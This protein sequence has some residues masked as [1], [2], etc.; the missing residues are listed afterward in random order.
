MLNR[1]GPTCSEMRLAEVDPNEGLHL[2]QTKYA[3]SCSHGYRQAIGSNR[4]A[5][6]RFS[7]P[8][9]QSYQERVTN[10]TALLLRPPRA[11]N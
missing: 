4:A 8:S 3:Y 5:L 9:P 10:E 1:Y 6:N 11:M 7:R 2:K